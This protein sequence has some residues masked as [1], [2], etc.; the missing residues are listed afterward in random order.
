[1]NEYE[2]A[3]KSLDAYIRYRAQREGVEYSLSP[4]FFW[5]ALTQN[6]VEFFGVVVRDGE[7]VSDKQF[8]EV[9][10]MWRKNQQ[11]N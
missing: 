2:R 7:L 1:M 8:P 5:D 9:F 10:A 3:A 11:L 6:C 4:G